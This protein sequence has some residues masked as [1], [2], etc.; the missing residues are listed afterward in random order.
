M[1]DFNFRYNVINTGIPGARSKHHVDHLNYFKNN[2]QVKIFLILVGANDITHY[3]YYFFDPNPWY[4][5]FNADNILITRI[6]R[7]ILYQ[8]RNKSELNVTA[9][10]NFKD[11]ASN[12][13]NQRGMFNKKKKK[14]LS[15]F[16][17]EK[18]TNEIKK[19]IEKISKAC[20]KT[21]KFCVIINQPTIYDK[22]NLSNDQVLNIIWGVPPFQRYSLDFK[23]ASKLYKIVNTH[24]KNLRCKNCSII[25]LNQAFNFDVQNFT[26]EIHF[27]QDGIKLSANLIWKHLI[28]NEILRK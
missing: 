14:S 16:E 18:L 21:D 11:D 17:I 19:D 5:F 13:Y 7:E 2:E 20:E 8:Y 26:D 25:D 6:A 1:I 24:I 3:I 22:K 23:T 10:I 27:S 9:D 15:S 4:K 28:D 12:V